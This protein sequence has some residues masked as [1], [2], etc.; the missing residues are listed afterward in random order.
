MRLF[1]LHHPA[2][3]VV[4]TTIL[5]QIQ[6]Q[7]SEFIIAMKTARSYL[8]RGMFRSEL[9]PIF[10]DISPINRSPVGQPYS[11][12]L[13]L[14]RVF[15][16]CSFGARR[17]NSIC[18]SPD[19]SDA[20]QFTSATDVAVAGAGSVYYIFPHNG[21]EFNWSK[22]IIDI[23]GSYELYLGLKQLQLDINDA[24]GLTKS[25][26]ANFVDKYGFSHENLP[27]ALRRGHEILIH[28]AYTAVSYYYTDLV[29]EFF[30]MYDGE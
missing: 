8:Y 12:Q 18:C 7:C 29:C 5:P 30:E 19:M 2:A 11:Q 27:A 26:A 9:N 28:G 17:R 24:T 22:H 3:E 16:M 10:S 14:D 23:G 25:M 1:E 20:E 13:L 4:N 15:D 21:F 6:Q